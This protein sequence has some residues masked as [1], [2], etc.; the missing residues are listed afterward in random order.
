MSYHIVLIANH[1]SSQVAM[2]NPAAERDNSVIA[3]D[4]HYVPRNP[5]EINHAPD[6]QPQNYWEALMFA[7][8]MY[9]GPL[10]I[11]FWDTG[12][13][14]IA[15]VTQQSPFTIVTGAYQGPA[16]NLQVLVNQNGTLTFQSATAAAAAG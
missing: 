16:G 7:N 10:D 8:F 5:P 15:Y 1:S 2:T 4:G 12:D 9:T 3:V 11:C 6:G 13:S 14:E